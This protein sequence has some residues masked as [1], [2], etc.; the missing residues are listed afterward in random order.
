MGVK[1]SGELG[2]KYPYTLR[3]KLP[4]VGTTIFTKMSALAKQEHALNLSQGFPEFDGG[5]ELRKLVNAQM[6]KGNNHYASML[7]VMELREA[8]AEKMQDCYS[9]IYHPE[10]EITVTAGGTQAISTAIAALVNEGDEVILFSPAYDCYAPNVELQGAKPVFVDLTPDDYG[11]DWQNLKRVIN[12]KTKMIVINTP[13]NPTGAVLNAEHMEKLGK[14]LEGTEII[15]L[16][17]EVYEHI[18]FDGLEHQSVARFPKLAE[19]SVLVYSLG[20]TYHNTGWRLGYCIAPENLM[21]EIRKVHQY[22]VFTCNTPMQYAFAQVLKDQSR[23][24]ELSGFYQEKRD[25]FR[26]LISSSNFRLLPCL[27]TYFQLLDYSQITD[28]NDVVYAEK[29]TK[30]NKIASIPV[31]VFYPNLTDNKVLRFCFAKETDTLHKAAEILNKI[32]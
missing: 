10:K 18:I 4:K 6:R 8:I 11:I 23:Y 31:S 1:N 14:L 25:M 30:E 13:H 2:M 15:L 26:S 20:K 32:S 22:S 7:G 19:R 29:L 24:K 12:Y 21:E 27:G 9:A 17:D 16:S 3:S 28:E 5:D